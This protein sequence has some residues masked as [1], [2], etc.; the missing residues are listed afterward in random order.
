[1]RIRWPISMA[2]SFALASPLGMKGRG[3]TGLEPPRACPIE[4]ENFPP[5][6]SSEDL[7]R[8]RLRGSDLGSIGVLASPQEG[9]AVVRAEAE[10]I[11]STYVS[12]RS[13][14]A[15]HS[16]RFELQLGT[17]GLTWFTASEKRAD[18]VRVVQAGTYRL[19]LHY[20]SPSESSSEGALL[21]LALSPTFEVRKNFLLLDV[22][23]RE[24]LRPA[25]P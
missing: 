25:K 22:D 13:R 14:E 18:S 20:R 9:F 21:C 11:E 16:R 15:P 1:M 2:I 3:S 6:L 17:N 7:L 5:G 12:Y 10:S 8:V 19:L 24:L 4:F 23:D